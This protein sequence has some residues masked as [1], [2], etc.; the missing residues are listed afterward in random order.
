MITEIPVKRIVIYTE[1]DIEVLLFRLKRHA[2]AT[3]HVFWNMVRQDDRDFRAAL[4]NA[5]D[6]EA[7]RGTN[8]TS[9][10]SLLPVP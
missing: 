10:L 6:R 1:Q 9:A 7:D 3:L 2:D 4:A 8:R 5:F